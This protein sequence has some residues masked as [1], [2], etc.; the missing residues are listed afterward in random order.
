MQNG[1]PLFEALAR[2]IAGGMGELRAPPLFDRPH[3][4]R[5]LLRV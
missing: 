5:A 1:L 4:R 3:H 2:R